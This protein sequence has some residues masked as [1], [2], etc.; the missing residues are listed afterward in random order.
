MSTFIQIPNRIN[1]LTS[2]SKLNEIFTYA[3]I[4]S[5]IKNSSYRAAIPQKQLAEL[6]GVNE[7]TIRNYIDTLTEAGLITDTTKQHGLGEYDHNVYKMDYLSED[8][9]MMNPMMITEESIEPKL[10]GLL[11]L[12]K[13]YCY[14]GTNCLPFNS[15]EHLA[16]MLHVGKNQIASY[17]RELEEK[18]FI[19]IK[20]KTLILSKEYFYLSVK[21]N[22]YNQLYETIYDY[23]LSQDA[24]PP[25]KDADR[26]DIGLIAA[27]F[28]HP[29]LLLSTLKN[30]CPKLPRNVS[31]S[32]FTKVIRNREA[33]TSE[34]T[35][36][37]IHID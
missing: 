13:T 5:Q 12:I 6:T 29:D 1:Q 37:E 18:G 33:E 8:Y 7:R 15:K 31:M 4:R 17:L 11:M 19:R 24:V 22:L 34:S 16:N 26:N 21:D 20:E 28:P 35:K 30:R 27:A 2:K 14:K 9:F 23:C 32:Y 25:F 36:Y 3:A 10:K